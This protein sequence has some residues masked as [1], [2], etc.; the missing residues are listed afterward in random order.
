M[1]MSAKARLNIT[2]SEQDVLLLR[3][4][5]SPRKMSRFI[6]EAATEKARQLKQAALRRQ[7]VEAYEADPDFLRNAGAEWDTISIEG[8]PKP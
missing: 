4:V 7:I 8:W 2:A 5:T 1:P 3:S 6:M